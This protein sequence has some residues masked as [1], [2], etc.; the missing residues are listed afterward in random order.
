MEQRKI[1][2]ITGKVGTKSITKYV[3]VDLPNFRVACNTAKRDIC[4][5][6]VQC[7]YKEEDVV[8]TQ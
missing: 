8:F 1:Y 7:G 2:A 4:Q 3:E 6:F 5:E